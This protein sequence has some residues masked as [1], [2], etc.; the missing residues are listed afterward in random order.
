MGRDYR[1]GRKDRDLAR[2]E[3][4]EANGQRCRK[5]A[6]TS[7]PGRI[8]R[9]DPEREAPARGREG[10]DVGHVARRQQRVGREDPDGRGHHERLAL[11]AVAARDEV[12]TQQPERRGRRSCDVQ[13]GD[14]AP[15]CGEERHAPEQMADHRHLAPPDESHSTGVPERECD[16]HERPVVTGRH[17]D[18]AGR[19]RGRERPADG[20]QHQAEHGPHTGRAQTSV[21]VVTDTCAIQAT[22]A[23]PSRPGA[24][25]APA[26]AESWN[27]GTGG[28]ARSGGD[29]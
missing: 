22:A 21:G 2:G 3:A 26:P 23:A 7:L 10:R 25:V 27:R 6:H 11:G 8:G 4:D 14:R 9:R 15:S 16:A 5:E 1:D 28:G 13:R 19:V 24:S 20:D 12:H 18:R 29:M 17:V